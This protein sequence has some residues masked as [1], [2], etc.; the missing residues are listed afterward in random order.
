MSGI[1]KPW[2]LIVTHGHLCEEIVKSAEMILG[3]LQ[4]VYTFPLVEGEEPQELRDKIRAVLD[5]A[6]DNSILLADMFGGTPA[7]ALAYFSQQ[8][9]YTVVSGLNLGMLIEAEMIRSQDNYSNIAEHL[10]ASALKSMVDIRRAMKEGVK[11]A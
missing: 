6:P 5:K 3:K 10:L 2:I 1:E 4:N 9:K 8:K 7:N 11:N